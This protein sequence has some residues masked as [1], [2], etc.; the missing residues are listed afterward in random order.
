MN[1]KYNFIF[2]LCTKSHL[3]EVVGSYDI[4][5]D[6]IICINIMRFPLHLATKMIY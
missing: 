1:Q 5:Y 2:L 6:V 4:A 3:D